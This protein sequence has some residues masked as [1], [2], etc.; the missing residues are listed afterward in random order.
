MD[1]TL[2]AIVLVVM[3]AIIV[4]AVISWV[5]DNQAGKDAD[6][7]EHDLRQRIDTSTLHD[8]YKRMLLDDLDQC[9]ARDGATERL[10]CIEYVADSIPGQ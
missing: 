10:V 9:N 1:N 5:L 2:Y 7:L 4:G 8:G 3:G 6:Q